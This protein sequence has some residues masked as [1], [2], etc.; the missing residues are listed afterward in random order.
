M[1]I[2]FE[3]RWPNQGVMQT[4]AE[5][6]RRRERASLSKEGGRDGGKEE[7]LPAASQS[8]RPHTGLQNTSCDATRKNTQRRLPPGIQQSNQRCTGTIWT[9]GAAGKE[10]RYRRPEVDPVG[11]W[12]DFIAGSG[13]QGLFSTRHRRLANLS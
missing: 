5:E 7:P 8:V 10:E 6:T 4:I 12:D 3:Q 2:V 9:S 1:C 11:F 13:G